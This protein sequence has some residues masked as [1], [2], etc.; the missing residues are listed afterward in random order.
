M[1]E[2]IQRITYQE[3][4]NFMEQLFLNFKKRIEEHHNLVESICL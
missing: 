2:L 4:R 3:S 1:L